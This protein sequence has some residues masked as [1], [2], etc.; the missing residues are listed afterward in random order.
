MNGSKQIAVLAFEYGTTEPSDVWQR[1][2]LP[3]LKFGFTDSW[4]LMGKPYKS[5]TLQKALKTRGKNHFSVDNEFA[6]ITQVSLGNYLFDKVVIWSKRN[7]SLLEWNDLLS[8]L[9]CHKGFFESTLTDYEYSFWQNAEDPTQYKSRGRSY[10]SLP[11]LTRDAPAPLNTEII[12]TSK[13]PGRE[14]LKPGYFEAVGGVMWLNN[15]FFEI[16]G[17]S[18]SE[19]MNQSFLQVQENQGVLRIVLDENLLSGAEKSLEMANRQDHL[20]RI[21]F[22]RSGT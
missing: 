14:V 11:V 16:T 20:R 2:K 10:E 21:L 4:K 19:L 6:R 8:P 15:R 13:N 3:L 22:P 5:D 1:V 9:F 18:I 7:L 17:A 12:D